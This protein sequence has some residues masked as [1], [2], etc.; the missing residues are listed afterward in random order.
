[1]DKIIKVLNL[2][3]WRHVGIVCFPEIKGKETFRGICP[4]EDFSV[5][6]NI[7]RDLFVKVQHFIRSIC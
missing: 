3:N 7:G 2:R 1:M 5:G 6:K 4:N